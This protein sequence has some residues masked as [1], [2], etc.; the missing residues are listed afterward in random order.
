MARTW[1]QGRKLPKSSP[2]GSQTGF[3]QEDPTAVDGVKWSPVSGI[4]SVTGADNGEVVII[5]GGVPTVGPVG[6]ADFVPA[7][8]GNWSPAPTTIQGA[9]DQ[10][11]ARITALEP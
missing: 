8:P 3:L 9:L 5:A 6:P 11:A 10:L 1:G 4:P 7:A 2:I